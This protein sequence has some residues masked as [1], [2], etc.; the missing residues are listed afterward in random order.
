MISLLKEKC[1]FELKPA[2]INGDFEAAAIKAWYAQFPG[3]KYQGC[4]FHF[5]Q[6]LNRNISEK[7]LK[8]EYCT[9]D[10][11]RS[12]LKMF[13]SL[14]FVPP[15]AVKHGL[16]YIE[17]VVTGNVELLSKEDKVAFTRAPNTFR[18]SSDQST[19]NTLRHDARIVS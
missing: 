1:P 17:W 8:K 18:S 12:W 13:K 16:S 4:N 9:N 7:G 11:Y 19:Y 3:V 15:H 6:A 14:A 5:T 10:I 2:V